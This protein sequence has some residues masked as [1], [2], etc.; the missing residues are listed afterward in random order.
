MNT[1]RANDENTEV[2]EE[3]NNDVIEEDDEFKRFMEIELTKTSSD[4]PDR[5]VINVELLLKVRKLEMFDKLA[6]KSNVFTFYEHFRDIKAIDN[7]LF[8]AAMTILAAPATQVSVE[9]AFSA[10]ALVMDD[11]RCNLK[12]YNRRHFSAWFEPRIN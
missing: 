3:R 8:E 9:R 2:L 12:Q 4:I 1:S 10:L 6:V 11:I 7:D 5:T